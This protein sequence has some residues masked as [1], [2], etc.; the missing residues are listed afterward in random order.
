M[1]AVLQDK[2]SVTS[3]VILDTSASALTTDNLEQLSET[4]KEEGLTDETASEKQSTKDDGEAKDD[5][6]TAVVKKKD[7]DMNPKIAT[8]IKRKK[9]A[10]YDKVEQVIEK[11]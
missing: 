3:P 1:N 7:D 6:E 2:H 4:E 8:G 10:K 5:G 9:Q 11:I